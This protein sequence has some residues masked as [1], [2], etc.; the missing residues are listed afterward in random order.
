MRWAKLFKNGGFTLIE[1]LVMISIITI[2][3]SLS[4]MGYYAYV[5]NA[6][7]STISTTAHAYQSTIKSYVF[8]A[9]TYPNVPFCLPSGSK[10][11]YSSTLNTTTVT[12]GTDAESGWDASSPI[13]AVSK[14]INNQPP[15]LPV[16]S[17]FISCTSGPM[18]NGPCKA[19]SSIAVGF[20]Y[21]PN[22]SGALYTSTDTKAKA[23]LVYYVDPTYDCNSSDVMTL[24][25]G[26][27]TFDSTAKYT[28]I[29]SSVPTYK[30]CIIG[31]RN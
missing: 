1:V 5:Q 18:S 21:I 25:S 31:V 30:E 19:T 20:T 12:C 10:C 22:N 14:Y 2:L 8:E 24:T 11:C 6:N 7:K 3:A 23:F 15:K 9:N 28:R 27:L 17:N 13:S 26:D 4:Y 16:F 29:Q